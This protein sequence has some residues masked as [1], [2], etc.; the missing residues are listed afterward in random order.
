MRP[1]H[2]VDNALLRAE[3]LRIVATPRFPIAP[4]LDRLPHLR[5]APASRLQYVL[6]CR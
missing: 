4:F 1:L 2:P 6:T 5:A 3:T